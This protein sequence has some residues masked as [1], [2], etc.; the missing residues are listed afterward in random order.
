MKLGSKISKDVNII[1][2]QASIFPKEYS[3]AL[4]KKAESTL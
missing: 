1:N 4:I 3:E 2:S